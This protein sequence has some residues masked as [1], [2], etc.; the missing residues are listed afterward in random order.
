MGNEL[1]KKITDATGL[2]SELVTQE[3]SKVLMDRGLSSEELT[4]EGL[5]AAMADYLREVILHAKDEF[6]EG[7]YIEEEIHPNDLGRED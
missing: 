5:R 1:F 6:E 7:V 4:L 2:P 3:L